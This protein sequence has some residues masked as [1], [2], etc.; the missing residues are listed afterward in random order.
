MKNIIIV[1]KSEKQR[2]GVYL[3]TIIGTILGGMVIVYFRKFL[4]GII[5]LL[6]PWILLLF[7]VLY[8]YKTWQIVFLSN[9]IYKKVFFL[10]SKQYSYFEIK[11]IIITHS[12]TEYDYIRII[13]SNGKYFQFR[14]EDENANSAINRMRSSH[15]IR[16]EE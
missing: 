6:L 1:K 5:I 13:F 11:D 2:I 4:K 10:C 9:K 7:I 8:Y 15:S 14:L 12:Y 16:I 3:L